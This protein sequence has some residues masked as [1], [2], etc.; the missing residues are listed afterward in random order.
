MSDR[1]NEF[2]IG[3]WI[4]YFDYDIMSQEE[5]MKRLV[6]LGINYQPFPFSWYQP[7]THDD[8]EDWKEI[9]RLCQ[10][11]GVLYG[12]EIAGNKLGTSEEAFE[13]NIEIGKKLS[14]NLVVYHLMDEPFAP[15]IPMLANWVR[16]YREANPRVMPTF[17]LNPSYTSARNL[18]NSFRGY[19]QEVV[20]AVGQENMVY[21]S[22]DFYPFRKEST[23]WNMFADL[24][25]MR[26]VALKNGALKTHAFLQANEFVKMRMPNIDEIRWSAYA[27]IAYGFKGLSYFNIVMPSANNYEG[28]TDGLIRQ[29]GSVCNE[30]LLENVGVLNME[31]RAVGNQTFNMQALHA[32]HTHEVCDY[33]ELLPKDYYIQPTDNE[34]KFVITEWDDDRYFVLFNN[35]FEQACETEFVVKGVKKLSV[36]NCKTKEY[37]PC[38]M[39]GERVKVQFA[40]GEGLLF[41]IDDGDSIK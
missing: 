6:R 21:L 35:D 27:H 13:K 40:K 31:L 39:N 34:R 11:Y 28:Y 10:K 38:V 2:M 17:N 15:Q 41:R 29:D 12:M 8:E 37:T 14:D 19:L 33:I 24:E 20:D 7:E 30:E 3:S 1:I 26:Y 18:N 23:R 22:F 36:F 4:T 32:Y 16:R 5:Q 25:D 9:D